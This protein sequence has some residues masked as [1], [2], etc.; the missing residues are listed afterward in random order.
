MCILIVN[1]KNNTLFHLKYDY[2]ERLTFIND[3]IRDSNIH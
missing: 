1:I 3:C 2:L